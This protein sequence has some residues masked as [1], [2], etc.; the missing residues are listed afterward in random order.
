MVCSSRW[1]YWCLLGDSKERWKLHSRLCSPG[2]SCWWSTLRL[3][4]VMIHTGSE[5]V[6]QCKC[7]TFSLVDAQPLHITSQAS[8]FIACTCVGPAQMAATKLMTR[9]QAAAMRRLLDNSH[10]LAFS[11][12]CMGSMGAW[13]AWVLLSTNACGTQGCRR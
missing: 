6:R 13:A 4:A 10:T 11:K 12:C 3:H 1:A 2:Q 7:Y 5:R 9:Q 8:L